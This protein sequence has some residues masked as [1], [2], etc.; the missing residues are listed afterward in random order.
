VRKQVKPAAAYKRL[1]LMAGLLLV[2]GL[3]LVVAWLQ[4]GVVVVLLVVLVLVVVVLLG[5]SF[6]LW[7]GEKRKALSR[8]IR[9]KRS[10]PNE[11]VA[12]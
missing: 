4:P 8:I 9:V 12:R 10:L 5:E 1:L 2:F 3:G 7:Q 11:G 6:H